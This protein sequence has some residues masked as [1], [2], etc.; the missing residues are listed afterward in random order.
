MPIT[1]KLIVE[2]KGY[3]QESVNRLSSESHGGED[4]AVFARGP[5]SYIIEG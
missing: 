1:G 2:N 5:L 4:V 3:K